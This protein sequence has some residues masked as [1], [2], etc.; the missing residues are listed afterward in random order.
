VILWVFLVLQTNYW[1][2]SGL[3]LY[4]KYIAEKKQIYP[5]RTG[6][7]RRP[8]PLRP[9]R[10]GAAAWPTRG[11]FGFTA[12]ARALVAASL[13]VRALHAELGGPHPYKTCPSPSDRASPC[14]QPRR[15]RPAASRAAATAGDRVGELAVRRRPDCACLSSSF[16]PVSTSSNSPRPPPSIP[17]AVEPLARRS[18]DTAGHQGRR[19]SGL[20]LSILSRGRR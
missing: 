14:S 1:S 7:A 11:P 8:D 15:R 19:P 20:P 18:T 5:T 13:G 12:M 10:T 6:R 17:R 4:W 2:F 3:L 9:A 16:A